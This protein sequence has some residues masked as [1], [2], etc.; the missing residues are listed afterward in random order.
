MQRKQQIEKVRQVRE[1]MTTFFD[2]MCN[3]FGGDE[4]VYNLM[5]EEKR[6]Y[7]DINMFKTLKEIGVWYCE[8]DSNIN[9]ILPQYT[10]QDLQDFGII[11]EG[12]KYLMK[13]RYVL[14]IRDIQ[15]NVISM[16]GWLPSGGTRKYLT[17]TSLG[18]SR[19]V[20]FFNFDSFK[21]AHEHFN[22]ATFEVEG[23]FGAVALRSLGLPVV[24]NMGLE[25]S[26]LKEQM[27][28]RYKKVITISDNDNGGKSVNPYL[29]KLV[30]HTNRVWK[31][32]TNTVHVVLPDLVEDPDDFVKY[33]DCRDDLIEAIGKKYL[34]KLK[35][36]E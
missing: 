33:Y 10:H 1:K 32:E 14:P 12:G 8:S 3:F 17:A 2:T 24:A 22:G 25:M 26:H 34:Y 13:G 36:E 4:V 28:S 6:G 16:V 27:L 19:A 15:G 29:A 5:C 23:I 20:S 30:G 35:L 9:L 21:Y 11:T 18:F 31:P 7:V